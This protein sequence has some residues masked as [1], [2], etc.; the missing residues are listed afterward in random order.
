MLRHHEFAAGA[1]FGVVTPFGASSNQITRLFV[2][3]PKGSAGGSSVKDVEDERM[4]WS[5]WRW[6]V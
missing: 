1:V 5:S 4:D 6:T 2:I 3:E